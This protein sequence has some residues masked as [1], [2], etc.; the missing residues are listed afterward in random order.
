Q[1]FLPLVGLEREITLLLV[2]LEQLAVP[3]GLTVQPLECRDG[4]YVVAIAVVDRTELRKRFLRTPHLVEQDAPEAQPEID[5]E[6]RVPLAVCT[7]GRT[8]VGLDERLPTPDCTRR[9]LDVSHAS[10]V[11]GSN[12]EGRQVALECLLRLLEPALVERR[13]LTEQ[14]K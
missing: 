13:H 2:D 11:A 12:L 14:R 8:G 9:A 5:G 10:F 3:P 7:L 6:R 1:N 4:R